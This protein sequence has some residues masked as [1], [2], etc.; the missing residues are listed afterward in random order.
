[1]AGSD[2]TR[3]NSEVVDLAIAVLIKPVTR[4]GNRNHVTNAAAEQT[5][6][7]RGYAEVA[8]SDPGGP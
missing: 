8:L 7:T 1:L 2:A 6:L 3:E 5:V 4:L